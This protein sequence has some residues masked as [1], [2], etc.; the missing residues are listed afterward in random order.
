MSYECREA[1]ELDVAQPTEAGVAV[2]NRGDYCGFGAGVGGR[3]GLRGGMGGHGCGGLIWKVGR[4]LP[5][6]LRHR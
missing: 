4:S 3:L 6:S 5:Y 1:A 2:L